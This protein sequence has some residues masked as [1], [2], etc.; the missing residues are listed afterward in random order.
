MRIVTVLFRPT[1]ALLWASALGFA[2]FAAELAAEPVQQTDELWSFDDR[3]LAGSALSYL[4]AALTAAALV[5]I[6]RNREDRSIRAVAVAGAVS[7]LAFAG[8]VVWP[9]ENH[10]APAPWSLAGSV[11]W[12]GSTRE[13]AVPRPHISPATL[14]HLPP[15]G[16][17]SV[18]D[19]I[20]AGFAPS[21]VTAEYPSIALQ[22]DTGDPW[23]GV[24]FVADA[25]LACEAR[26]AL[27]SFV[28]DRAG[29]LEHSAVWCSGSAVIAVAADDVDEL[30]TLREILRR[31]LPTRRT[32]TQSS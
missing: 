32:P 16:R 4:A 8:I 30:E 5:G 11:T 28:A 24:V 12:A 26:D 23:L 27:R 19:L 15:E 13:S 25:H 7:V 14:R 9:H 29:E 3:P 10:V 6:V 20:K 18:I 2:F 31:H 17:A 1:I 21:V 22:R